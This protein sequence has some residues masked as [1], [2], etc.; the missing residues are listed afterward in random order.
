MKC[1]QCK[2]A[3]ARVCEKHTQNAYCGSACQKLYHIGLKDPDANIDD[4][5]I[6]GLES[7]DGVKFRVPR[8]VIYR[9]GETLKNLIEDAGTDVYIPLPNIRSNI[10][11]MLIEF[12]NGNKTAEQIF[13]GMKR[14]PAQLYLD[15]MEAANYLDGDVIKSADFL[16][17]L[18]EALYAF[19][20]QEKYYVLLK[21]LLV[22]SALFLDRPEIISKTISI[23]SRFENAEKPQ[24]FKNVLESLRL[25]FRYF[26]LYKRNNLYAFAYV[27]NQKDNDMLRLLLS[28]RR[29]PIVREHIPFYV[30]VE[31]GNAE[32]VQILI[33][34]NRADPIGD[35]IDDLFS[36][37]CIKGQVDIMRLLYNVI[38]DTYYDPKSTYR[39]AELNVNVFNF[40]H[41]HPTFMA[42][43]D[44]FAL[45]SVL[46][47]S[48]E[49][50]L[51]KIV[52]MVLKQPGV[53]PAVNGNAPI[54]KAALAG[55]D[56]VVRLLLADQRV[57]PREALSLATSA[58]H[59]ETVRLLL[60]DPRVDPTEN[61]YSVLRYAASN[62]DI[63]IVA[64]F[65][66][67]NR[68]DPSAIN[69]EGI[70]EKIRRLINAKK[71]QRLQNKIR[72]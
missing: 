28:D 5:D 40:F 58:R 27:I 6:I 16:K 12:S 49:R 1:I 42:R 50:G 39:R 62:Y 15:L 70:S 59:V 66:A 21:G 54:L 36:S 30:A 64:L 25:M 45:N 18:H 69:L 14:P 20:G 43:V 2:T 34:D 57:D 19:G 68:V 3:A 53:N 51:S 37:A 9:M 56:E 72:R 60:S 35:N 13:W 41:E 11:E 52:E 8:E 61:N 44:A 67:D 65:L 33:R 47:K 31:N 38:P 46:E 24:R 17:I 23:I 55:H 7:A 32:A 26:R 10:V 22:K 48:S 63:E 71:R 29:A 4:D